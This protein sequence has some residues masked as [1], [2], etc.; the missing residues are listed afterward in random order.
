MT[1]EPMWSA[2]EPIGRHHRTGGYRRFAWT[3]ED[4]DL[5]EWFAGE[6]GRRELGAVGDAD[7]ARVDRPADADPSAVVDRH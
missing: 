6:L 4:H 5:R 3:R 1:F 2:I 7:L